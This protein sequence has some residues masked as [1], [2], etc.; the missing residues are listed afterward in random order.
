M[1]YDTN[2]AVTEHRAAAGTEGRMTTRSMHIGAANPTTTG[3]VPLG[4]GTPSIARR[5]LEVVIA[6][7]APTECHASRSSSLAIVTP[8][9]GQSPSPA[10]SPARESCAARAPTHRAHVTHGLTGPYSPRP[11]SPQRR[12]AATPIT[13]G[14]R[15]ATAPA[16][17]PVPARH[18][19]PPATGGGQL[20]GTSLRRC[21]PPAPGI[22]ITA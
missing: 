11:Q 8:D 1:P 20:R 6:I 12:G 22:I 17:P 15:Q 2:K 10:I 13:T 16:A 7:A 21:S 9:D 5:G 19:R 4:Y 18:A 3:G 14:T